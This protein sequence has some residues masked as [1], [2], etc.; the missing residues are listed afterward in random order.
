MSITVPQVR[1]ELAHFADLGT[2]PPQEAGNDE[3]FAFRL[4]REGERLELRFD[5]G[6]DGRVTEKSL[7]SG[8]AREHE[9]YRALLASERFGDLRRWAGAQAA[10]LGRTLHDIDHRPIPVRG[11]LSEGSADTDVQQIDDLLVSRRDGDRSASSTH[12]LLI[13]GPAGIGKTK[14]IELLALERA[15]R[16]TSTQRPLVLHVQSRG[17]VLTFLQDLIAFSL[18][19][20]RLRVT[21]D[22]LPILVRHGLVSLAIDGFD[23]LGDPNGYDLAWGQ[24]NDLVNEVRGRGIL[25]LSGR[26]TFIGRERLMGSIKTLSAERDVVDVLSLHPPAPDVARKWLKES[27]KGWSDEDLDAVEELFEPDSYTLRPFFL[28]QLADREVAEVFRR[29]ALGY[30]LAFLVELMI[31]REAGKFGEAVENVM[32]LDGRKRFVQD[33][34]REMARDMADQQSDVLDETGILWLVDMAVPEGIP[35][36]ARGLLRNRA[37]VMAFLTADERP[38]Y[39]RFAH[40]QLFNHFLSEVTMDVLARQEVPK[41]IRRNILGADFLS[42]FSALVP[43]VAS[44]NE[45]RVQYF[46]DAVRGLVHSYMWTDRGARNMGAL[47]VATLPA[48]SGPELRL[49]DLYVDEALLQGSAAPADMVR[50]T[51]NQLDVR[52]ADLGGLHFADSTIVTLIAN[53]ATRVSDSFPDPSVIRYEGFG[54]EPDAVIRAP[55]QIRSWVD[56]HGR[57]PSQDSRCHEGAIP[58]ALREHHMVRLLERV[59][60]VRSYWIRDDPEDQFNRFVG[61]PM[62]PELLGLL[63]AHDLARVRHPA[64]SGRKDDFVHIVNAPGILQGLRAES[65][66]AKTRDFHRALT[67]RILTLEAGG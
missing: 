28:A 13:D 25:I 36:E 63:K 15:R 29:K 5:D 26:E 65:S 1:E 62:W 2:S 4:S 30:P 45:Q 60:R 24:V 66:D 16:F 18:Q 20:L 58:E 8:E 6:V 12:I 49:E 44:S 42:A 21:Y 40:S 52:G 34:L 32:D 27:E 38:G 35:S 47:L 9:S 3:R 46:F 41:F 10:S 7:D 22:Q 31:E 54:M 59:C 61:D 51:V 56:T 64:T 67:R 14:F 23:E 33:F 17:R 43:H 37:N 50:V 11:V 19:T 48:A 53:D 39:R 57:A 55:G